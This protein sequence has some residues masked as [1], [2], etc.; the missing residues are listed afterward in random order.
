MA[1]RHPDYPCF[2]REVC[3]RGILREP[4]RLI[5]VGVRGGIADHWLSFGDYLE[6]WGFDVLYEE[7]V[8]PLIE[9]NDHPERL[10][11][12]NIGLG[13]IDGTRAF[14]FY[15]EIRRHLITLQAMPAM[16]WTIYCRMFP[17]VDWI[18]Y[19]QTTQL[20]PSIL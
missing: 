11:Y 9:A 4:F 6:A 18:A 8:G 14:K 15:P 12:L 3:K 13:D 1:H 16:E 7:G 20:V 17:F 2:T 19:T 10:H 5:D